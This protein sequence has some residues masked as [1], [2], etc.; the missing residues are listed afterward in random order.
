MK[1]FKFSHLSKLSI[2]IIFLAIGIFSSLLI[3]AF[4]NRTQA[5]VKSDLE[6]L[7]ANPNFSENV[8][9]KEFQTI[10]DDFDKMLNKPNNAE[11]VNQQIVQMEKRMD[12]TI[13][14]HQEQIEKNLKELQSSTKETSSVVMREDDSSYYYILT[15]SGYKKDEIETKFKD[16]M[17]NFSGAKKQVNTKNKSEAMTSSSFNYSFALPP[18]DLSKDPQI[19]QSEN[20]V[21]VRLLKKVK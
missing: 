9:V 4:L 18:Y 14:K 13:K 8:L 10:S 17:L 20:N 1:G 16:N 12:E 7:Q 5:A 15:F 11:A 19:T 3:N 21:T 6:K 2:A